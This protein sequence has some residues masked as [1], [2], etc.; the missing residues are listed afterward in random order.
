MKWKEIIMPKPSFVY[1]TTSN[2]RQN[3]QENFQVSECWW[4][5]AFLSSYIT[6]INCSI[7]IQDEA[8]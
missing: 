2:A 8:K 6:Q 7:F 5:K 1:C 4:L 3:G